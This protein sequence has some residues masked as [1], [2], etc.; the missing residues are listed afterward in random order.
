LTILQPG[1]AAAASIAISNAPFNLTIG[2]HSTRI[3]CCRTR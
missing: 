2:K 3:K 1:K